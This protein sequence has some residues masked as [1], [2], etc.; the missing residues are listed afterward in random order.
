M[1]TFASAFREHV[2]PDLRRSARVQGARLA[3]DRISFEDAYAAVF[4][5][6]RKRGAHY[7]DEAAFYDL[8]DWIS[9]Q[10]LDAL[11]EFL[12]DVLAH[13]EILDRVAADIAKCE[14]AWT[15]M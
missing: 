8:R 6:A 14:A 1:T 9:I 15:T 5:I 4:E 7:L 10:I 2:T 11:N 12:P 13:R 3:L